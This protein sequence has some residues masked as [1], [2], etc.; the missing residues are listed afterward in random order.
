MSK[1]SPPRCYLVWPGDAWLPWTSPWGDPW[2]HWSARRRT[3]PP[4]RSLALWENPWCPVD[5]PFHQSVEQWEHEVYIPLMFVGVFF[6]FHEA[7]TLLRPYYHSDSLRFSLGFKFIT[8]SN[9][10]RTAGSWGDGIVFFHGLKPS[11]ITFHKAFQ[12]FEPW[13]HQNVPDF[14]Q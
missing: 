14:Q 4:S 7:W 5:C 2:P 13:Y 10:D 6:Y 8:T 12:G 11:P 1:H 3:R 9:P